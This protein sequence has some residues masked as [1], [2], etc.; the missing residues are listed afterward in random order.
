M[1]KSAVS[2]PF[3]RFFA[4]PRAPSLPDGTRLYAI[5]DIHGCAVLLDRLTAR[6]VDDS[7]TAAGPCAL[8]YLGDYVDRGPDSKGVIDRLLAPPPGFSCSYLRG[9]H[10]QVVLDFLDDPSVFRTWRDFG[11]RETLMS[12]GVVPPRFD[13]DE[14]YNEAAAALRAALPPQHLAFLS[15]LELS[16]TVGG[17]FFSH[18]GVRPGIPLASQSAQDL[19]WIREDFLGSRANFGAVVVHGHTPMERP[20]RTANRIGVDTGAYATGRLTAAVLE[21]A[22]CRF[23]HT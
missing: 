9:N 3:K 21:G 14:A 12:Y 7:R 20:Q 10:D 22:G 5:G 2:N 18:A 16:L 23:L 17:Y 15:G 8:V 4:K 19:M 1:V 13:D 11:A 6:I